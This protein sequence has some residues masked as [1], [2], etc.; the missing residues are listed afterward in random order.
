M[1]HEKFQIVR[2]EDHRQVA[3]LKILFSRFPEEERDARL[4]D[5]LLS[6][7]RGSL[8]LSGLWIAEQ[9]GQPVGA[10]LLMLQADGVCLV[11]PPV[12]LISHEAREIQQAL[13]TT[14]CTELEHPDVRFGQCLLS[15]HEHEEAALLSEFG[16]EIA[17]ELFFLARPLEEPWP[18]TELPSHITVETF[19]EPGN[20]TRFEK[21][22]EQTYLESQDCPLLN[23]R[24]TGKE[25]IA[26]HRLSG[27]FHP[28]GWRLYS[29][30]GHDI[31]LVMLN[32]HP[33]QD[34]VE[35]VYY[36]VCPEYR[37]QGW[38]R[39]AICDALS[40]AKSWNRAVMFLA[41]D[42]GNDFANVIY[43]EFGFQEVARRHVWLKFPQH[44]ARK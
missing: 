25:A 14:V 36:G 22:I 1:D 16:F 24:R 2:A 42:A 20:V 10:T 44:S 35:L 12:A 31:G 11:W 33:D 29:N 43:A 30:N 21:V 6:A 17:S 40:L 34:A 19:Q 18:I 32:E 39:R 38:G 7:Q 28:R 23:G 5:S 27:E 3:A 41:V 4:Q 26:G 9:N 13:M 37:G 8:D 15:P